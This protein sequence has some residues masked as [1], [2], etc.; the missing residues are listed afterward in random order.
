MLIEQNYVNEK[1]KLRISI[2]SADLI[3]H[4]AMQSLRQDEINLIRYELVDI[5][6]RLSNA[7]KDKHE[8]DRKG[9]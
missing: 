7:L 1:Y 5:V 9:S 3:T 6:Q 8:L 4:S 2:S